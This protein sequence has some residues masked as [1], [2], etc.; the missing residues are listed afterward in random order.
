MWPFRP[1]RIYM[2]HASAT[3]VCAEAASAYRRALALYANPG[4]IHAEGVAAREALAR[5]R[6]GVARELAVKPR[7][8]VFV[9]GATE[10][11]NLCI[12][13]RAHRIIAQKGTLAGTHWIVSAIEHPSV[14]EAFGEIERL[15][16]SVTHADPQADGRI[17]PETLSRAL[18]PETVFVSIG[19]ANS[20]TGVVQ[21]L[22]ALR[23]A[24]DAR[25]PNDAPLF[26]SDLGQAPLYKAPQVHTLGLD[27]A[28]I[29]S[30]KLY[31]PRGIGAVYL[32]HRAE[33][34]PLSFGGDQE[35]ALRAGTEDVALAAGFAAALEAAGKR[36]GAE[37][38][39][40]EKLR[41]ELRAALLAR[42]PDLV[43]NTPRAHALPH[44]LNVSLPGSEGEYLASRLDRAG[45]AVSTKS[46]CRGGERASHVILALGGGE[47]RA[48]STIRFSLGLS[49][50]SRD[51]LRTAGAL[52]RIVAP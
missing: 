1:S 24:I 52:A 15:G 29:G 27:L 31:G 32:S 12:L 19:W 38:K 50:R 43:E 25:F 28:V 37:S 36:R 7:Q 49:T 13:G 10:G 30:G 33:I 14:L 4:A 47:N 21:P 46:A 34:A 35:R 45:I 18:K 8:L 42:L 51:I 5:A 41:D 6:E 23:E 44:L 3:P 16:G 40:L 2:D 9:S 39:R 20:E 26:H 11:N 17:A 48:V 22:R